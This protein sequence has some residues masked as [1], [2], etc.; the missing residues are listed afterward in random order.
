MTDTVEWVTLGVMTGT[1]SSGTL[2]FDD[3][4]AMPRRYYRLTVA[5]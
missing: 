3:Y 2:T 1:M 5:R 4:G